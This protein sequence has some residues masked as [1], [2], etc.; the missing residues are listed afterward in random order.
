VKQALSE[1]RL[2]CID[3]ESGFPQL[4]AAMEKIAACKIDLESLRSAIEKVRGVLKLKP[5]ESNSS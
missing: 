3:Q 2:Q 5:I 4:Q 1:L